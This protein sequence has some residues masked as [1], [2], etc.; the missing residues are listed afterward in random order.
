MSILNYFEFGDICLFCN[1]LAEA[2]EEEDIDFVG[3]IKD[4]SNG[5]LEM[6]FSCFR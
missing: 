5:L 4:V 3:I 1:N 2:H 6:L